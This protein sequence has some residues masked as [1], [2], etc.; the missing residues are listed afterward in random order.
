MMN[1]KNAIWLVL[2]LIAVSIKIFSLFPDA[3][4]YYYS[5]SLYPTISRVQRWLFGWLPISIGDIMYAVL[6]VLLC[7]QMYRLGR[8]IF[9]RNAN[10]AY[11]FLVARRF[12]RVVI[13]VYI[14]FNLL[15]GL[16]Y[17]RHGIER[18]L[19]LETASYSRDDLV[20]VMWKLSQKV[21]QFREPGLPTRAAL[22]RKKNLFVTADSAYGSLSASNPIFRYETRSVKPSL[23]S[24]LGN[25]M[26]FT[27]YYNPFS[28]EAQVNTTVPEFLRP[29]TTCHEI[30]HQLGF[31][32]ESEAN[33]AAYLS[34][35]T[36]NDSAF[37]Y[38]VYFD[39]Y[40]YGRPYLYL[41]DSTMLRSIDSTLS[42]GV[43]ADIE[44]LR[45]FL[46]SYSNPVENL[47]DILY[48][49]YL[50]ANQQPSGK[51]SYNEVIGL[52]IAYYKKYGEL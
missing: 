30:G 37:R 20:A 32:K 25:Y 26:G 18:K 39:M 41:M 40:L 46:R 1:R 14:C 51:L 17:N 27:G 52:L 47:I 38:S 48:G 4:E 42:G 7:K 16:N 2:F 19:G 9:A 34:G 31:A 50:R 29:F 5:Q 21:N 44:E 36:S 45:R 49:Q 43:K 15:W 23:Y 22:D 35:R 10:R 11:W 28:G 24:Y 8:R 3:V 33:F 13:V 12:L 6:F